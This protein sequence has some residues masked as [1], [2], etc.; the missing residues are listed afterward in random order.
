[1][2]E[3]VF[4]RRRGVC[5]RLSFEFVSADTFV[6]VCDYGHSGYLCPCTHPSH[7]LLAMSLSLS[8]VL[9]CLV[10]C[11]RPTNDTTNGWP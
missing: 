5:F 3:R 2:W 11:T 6:C 1:M 9:S 7:P 10:F 8:F 4:G